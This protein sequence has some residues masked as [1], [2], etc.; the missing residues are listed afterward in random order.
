MSLDHW[1]T[2]ETHFYCRNNVW[3]W[4]KFAWNMASDRV[5]N[6]TF[7]CTAQLKKEK[8][9]DQHRERTCMYVCGWSKMKGGGKS[10]RISISRISVE[11]EKKETKYKMIRVPP[12]FSFSY[13]AGWR[14]SSVLFC[15]FYRVP[16]LPSFSSF[17]ILFPKCFFYYFISSSLSCWTI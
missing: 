2:Y 9:V 17:F 10:I 16:F 6:R 12:Y 15:S 13:S 5:K 14:Q 3:F 8:K 1:P 11:K 7:W 4:M